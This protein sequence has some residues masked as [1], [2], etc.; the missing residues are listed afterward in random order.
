MSRPETNRLDRVGHAGLERERRERQL[1]A[2]HPTHRVVLPDQLDQLLNAGDGQLLAGELGVLQ[3]LEELIHSNLLEQEP[4][5]VQ[6]VLTFAD[7]VVLDRQILVG[8]GTAVAITRGENLK[9]TITVHGE[10]LLKLG[11]L[12]LLVLRAN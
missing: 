5:W 11:H 3:V 10:S 2:A 8:Q 9:L 7:H 12:S 4:T 1:D 6:D